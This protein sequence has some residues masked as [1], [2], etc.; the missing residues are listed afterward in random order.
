MQRNRVTS[1]V[2][3][4]LT[5]P[6]SA[7]LHGI[8]KAQGRNPSDIAGQPFG[9]MQIGRSRHTRLRPFA[10]SPHLIAAFQQGLSDT[11]YVDGTD[12]DGSNNGNTIASSLTL[13]LTTTGGSGMIVALGQLASSDHIGTPTATGATLRASRS[14]CEALKTSGIVDWQ[15]G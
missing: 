2:A 14:D 3:G 4:R 1:M 11:G 6:H 9:R 15:N 12:L 10:V 5:Y 13:S 7:T 8:R